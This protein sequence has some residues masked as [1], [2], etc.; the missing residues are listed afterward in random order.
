MKQEPAEMPRS[1]MAGTPVL[2]GRKDVKLLANTAH[3]RAAALLTLGGAAL[4]F[5]LAW[6]A[7]NQGE[8]VATAV[9][10]AAFAAILLRNSALPI[11]LALVYATATLPQAVRVSIHPAGLDIDLWE[12][13]LLL[14]VLHTHRHMRPPRVVTRSAI[15]LLFAIAFAAAVGYQRNPFFHLFNETR[16]HLD[17][18]AALYIAAGVAYH[19]RLREYRATVLL[20]LWGSAAVLLLSSAL[21]GA[22]PLRGRTVAASLVGQASEATRLLTNTQFLAAAAVCACTAL[23]LARQRG[24]RELLPFAAPAL[25]IIFLSFSRNSLLALGV[26]FLVVLAVTASPL[27]TATTAATAAAVALGAGWLVLKGVDGTAV[28]SYLNQQVQAY[29]G[30]VFTGV[31]ADVIANDPSALARVAENQNLLAAF[32][33]SPLFGNGYGYPYQPPFGEPGTFTAGLGQFYAHNFYL[34]L[35]AK[36][37]LLGAAAWLVAIVAPLVAGLRRRHVAS[38]GFTAAAFG[39]LAVAY[40]APLPNEAPNSIIVGAVVGL[41]VGSTARRPAPAPAPAAPARAAVDHA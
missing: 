38:V 23:Y 16:L 5:G 27:R 35:L 33:Q 2:Q 24:A 13:L 18:V 40:V 41:A 10:A 15:I 21:G 3:R 6:L 31:E 25:L 1:G 29:V 19:R 20:V 22:L 7:P 36:A 32:W 28:G 4:A 26:T 11:H 12:P 14:G 34:W 30:R 39:L 17:L 37:G 8:L 9:L